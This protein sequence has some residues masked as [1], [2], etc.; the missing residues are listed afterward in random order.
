V[1]VVDT[2]AWFWWVTE[3]TRLSQAAR[4]RLRQD[5]DVVVPDVCLWEIAMMANRGRL[6][7]AV[8]AARFL[9]EAIAWDDVRVQPITP[10]VA[11]RG[12]LLGRTLA[13]D[14]SD[15]LIAATALELRAPL[16]TADER[17]R[18]VPGLE[19]VW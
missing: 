11:I 1:I 4:T 18:Q 2:H 13:L 16:A 10:G 8:N 17:L 14:P 6:S 19:I 12:E 5:R 3:S 7:P 15:S 9:D